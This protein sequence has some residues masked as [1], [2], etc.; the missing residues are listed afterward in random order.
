MGNFGFSFDISI[1]ERMEVFRTTDHKTM[2]C[3]H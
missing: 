1:V 2:Q 3:I